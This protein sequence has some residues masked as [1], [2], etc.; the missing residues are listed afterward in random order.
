MSQDNLFNQAAFSTMYRPDMQ[1]LQFA[2]SV[3]HRPSQ[4]SNQASFSFDSS[5]FQSQEALMQHQQLMQSFSTPFD[6]QHSQSS[7]PPPASA[8]VV[9]NASSGS[10]QLQTKAER[11]AEHNAI[12][13]AR[14][15]SLNVKFQQ[16]AFALP[17]LQNDTRPSKSTIID[18]TLDFV[19]NAIQKEERYQRRIKELEKFNSY[20]LSESDKRLQH[21]KAK[22]S[23]SKMNTSRRASAS[24]SPV[25]LPEMVSSN[26]PM[27]ST[28]IEKHISESEVED[29]EDDEDDEDEDDEDAESTKY[30]KEMEKQEKEDKQV[31]TSK[32]KQQSKPQSFMLNAASI[33]G[34]QPSFSVPPS[35]VSMVPTSKQDF[36]NAQPFD[37]NLLVPA[38]KDLS[39]FQPQQN[40]LQMN[41]KLDQKNHP[42]QMMSQQPEIYHYSQQTMT[43]NSSFIDI[44]MMEGQPQ[45]RYMH[46]R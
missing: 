5:P 46:R 6:R 25:T 33:N 10:K 20:L 4:G 44:R 12:E 24:S 9:S 21:K 18:R 23:L 22:K 35:S 17:N 43:N 19:K 37:N 2:A 28:S 39:F 31:F 13:R 14:R 42:Q 27:L 41:H 34:V 40:T 36:W 3:P 38:T 32:L 11:R 7:S 15:E 16:L 8:S 1:Q 26:S 45:H 30:S 29:E